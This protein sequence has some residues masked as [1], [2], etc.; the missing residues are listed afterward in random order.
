MNKMLKGLLVTVLAVSAAQADSDHTNKTFLMPRPVGVN[1][2]MEYTTFAELVGRKAED[3]FGGNFQVTPF[4]QESNGDELGEYFLFNHKDTVH[5][6]TEAAINAK[7]TA[8]DLDLGYLIHSYDNKK[9]A[10]K[11]ASLSLDPQQ[12]AYGIRFDYVQDLSK[13]LKGLYL[14]VSLPVVHVENDLN[15][16]VDAKDNADLQKKLAHYLKGD[17]EN[18]EANNLTAK[19]THAKMGCEQSETGVADIDV[20]LG[21]KFLNKENYHAALALAVTIPTSDEA[22]GVHAFEA[23]VGNGKHFGLGGD[24]CAGARV[25]GDVDHN[26][27]LYL[28]A[29]YRYLFENS[30][31]RTLGIKDRAFGQYLLLGKEGQAGLIPAANVTTLDVDVT[32]GSQFD[33]ILGLAYNNGGFTFDLG[34]NMYFREDEDVDLKNCFKDGVYAVAARNFDT[35]TVG[36]FKVANPLFCDGN[37]VAKAAV[38][39]DSLNTDAAATPSQFTNSIY[40]GVGYIFKEWDTPVMLNLGGKYEWASKNSAF[41]QWGVWGKVGIGF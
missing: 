33:G 3:K 38:N 4:Y 36:G 19:L 15:V 17:F 37:D 29:K 1:V 9:V 30:E 5:F 34:Y 13:I 10:E 16:D 6:G 26:I 12:Q 21:Y 27:K 22:D 25:W 11:V 35:A 7:S 31:H 2:P 28:T 40:G 41:E 18:T 24:L 8:K 20:A 14:N 39:K 23:I 32:P